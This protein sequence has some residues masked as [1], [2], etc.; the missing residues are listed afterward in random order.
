MYMTFF[1]LLWET[2]RPIKMVSVLDYKS[3]SLGLPLTKA[4]VLF[5]LARC[6]TVKVSLSTQLYKW[7]PANLVLGVTL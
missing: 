3:N 1:T 4:I 7:V 6:L 5:Y 2:E